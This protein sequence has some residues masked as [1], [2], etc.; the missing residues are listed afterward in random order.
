MLDTRPITAYLQ[1]VAKLLPNARSKERAYRSDL[2]NLATKV[3]KRSCHHTG[4]SMV[5]S[6]RQQE[7]VMNDLVFERPPLALKTF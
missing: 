7:S 5:F 1:Q 2:Q 4:N 6:V 3:W